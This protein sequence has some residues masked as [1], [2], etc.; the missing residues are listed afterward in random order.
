MLIS[1]DNIT[2][3]FNG[4]ILFEKV[5]FSLNEGDRVGLIGPNGEG[6]TTLIRLLLGELEPESGKLFIKNGIRYVRLGLHKH[7]LVL[8]SFYYIILL[9]KNQVESLFLPL[10][11]PKSGLFDNFF[12]KKLHRFGTNFIFS[13]IF[14]KSGLVFI[15]NASL[16][17]TS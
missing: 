3:G 17:S 5:T 14:A 7:L 15:F 8:W 4:E 16:T 12:T 2:F 1:A 10:S 13:V 9:I 11:P 6:K